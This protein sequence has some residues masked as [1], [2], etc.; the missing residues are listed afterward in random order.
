MGLEW[1]KIGFKY[2]GVFIGDEEVTQ[3]NW[4]GIIEKVKGRLEKW[5]WL[6]PKMSFRGRVLIV[7][8]LVA[9]SLWHKFA[10]LDPPLTLLTKLQALLVDFFLG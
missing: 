6:L 4:E 8:N 2:L 10:C 3:K 5:K 7:N 9:S 1:G